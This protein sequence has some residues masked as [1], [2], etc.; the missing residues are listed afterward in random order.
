MA[1]DTP[2]DFNGSA[3]R[4]LSRWIAETPATSERAAE[5]AAHLTELPTEPL[6]F[7]SVRQ[8]LLVR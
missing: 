6:A 8:T 5:V 1:R 4:W 3:L 7:E 2:D